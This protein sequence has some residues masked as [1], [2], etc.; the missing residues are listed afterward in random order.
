M[1]AASPFVERCRSSLDPE[2][3]GDISNLDRQSRRI[4]RHGPVPKAL[5]L[6]RCRNTTFV[7]A[8]KLR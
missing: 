4:E 1:A 5:D 7:A 2:V 6:G 8:R 3:G